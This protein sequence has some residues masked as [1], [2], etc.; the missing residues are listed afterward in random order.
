MP[1][2]PVC[3]EEESPQT[4]TRSFARTHTSTRPPARTQA[5]MRARAVRKKMYPMY[6]FFLT[7]LYMHQ[8]ITACIYRT[9]KQ[10]EKRCIQTCKRMKQRENLHCV[11]LRENVWL[12]RQ[13][14]N[15]HRV[16]L[17]EY[18]IYIYY[19][20]IYTY[21]H[22]YMHTYINTCMYACMYVFMYVCMDVCMCACVRVCGP[23]VPRVALPDR[24]LCLP[25][26]CHLL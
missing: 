1:S 17:R 12:A 3:A 22:T 11:P 18:Y 8:C 6:A 5:R 16:A 21:I 14:E 26:F 25:A 23:R 9:G 19:I 4:P 13:R 15:S 7:C 24:A 10:F 2:V 20:Y